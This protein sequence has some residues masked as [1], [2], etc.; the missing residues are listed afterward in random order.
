MKMLPV[1]AAFFYGVQSVAAV[2]AL[3]FFFAHQVLAQV[4]SLKTI[5]AYTSQ[6]WIHKLVSD[7]QIILNRKGNIRHIKTIIIFQSS[8]VPPFAHSPPRQRSHLI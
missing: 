5:N 6:I 2:M 4:T 8:V 1:C 3:F 7:Q